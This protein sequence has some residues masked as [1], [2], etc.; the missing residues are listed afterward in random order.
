MTGQLCLMEMIS[1]AYNMCLSFTLHPLKSKAPDVRCQNVKMIQNDSK[2]MS[3]NTPVAMGQLCFP[4]QALLFTNVFCFL[5]D[6]TISMVQMHQPV[7]SSR[8]LESLLQ[9]YVQQV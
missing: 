2:L 5:N 8:G 3:Y 1:L 6:G 7:S 9:V 4:V